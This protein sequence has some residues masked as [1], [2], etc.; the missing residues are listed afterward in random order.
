MQVV[1]FFLL[2]S[3]CMIPDVSTC[4]EFKNRTN[5]WS[6]DSWLIPHVQ[7]PNTRSKVQPIG[8][9]LFWETL[10]AFYT[11]LLLGC[12]RTEREGGKLSLL[13][14]VCQRLFNQRER[15]WRVM[16]TIWNSVC[17]PRSPPSRSTSGSQESMLLQLLAW[18]IP[19]LHTPEAASDPLIVL[20]FDGQRTKTR[21]HQLLP[22]IRNLFF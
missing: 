16:G 15:E 9:F 10:C 12:S 13:H 4:L 7:G 2:S 17:F 3:S 6:N 20:H 5:Y 8:Y 1:L 21:H 18:R 11:T 19:D 22:V 14:D